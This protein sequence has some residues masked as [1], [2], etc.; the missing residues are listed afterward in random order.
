[1]SC[2]NTKLKITQNK[3]QYWYS[4]S[5]GQGVTWCDNELGDP[6]QQMHSLMHWFSCSPVFLRCW[7][8]R[9]VDHDSGSSVLL[10]SCHCYRIMMVKIIPTLLLVVQEPESLASDVCKDVCT[11]QAIVKGTKHHFSSFSFIY[12]HRS[13]TSYFS[14]S[15]FHHCKNMHLLS[16][17]KGN[18]FGTSSLVLRFLE[19]SSPVT[20]S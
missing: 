10:C 7:C 8:Q 16:F 15:A 1:M 5:L 18:T 20:L 3:V 11:G 14:S 9:F 4:S 12:F 13:K 19:H 6:M 2:L 17:W